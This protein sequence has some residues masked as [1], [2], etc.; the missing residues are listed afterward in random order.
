MNANLNSINKAIRA[1][2]LKVR[3]VRGPGFY[4]WEA[5][6][7]KTSAY[8]DSVYLARAADFP[9]DR[10]VSLARGVRLERDSPVPAGPIRIGTRIN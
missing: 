2:G 1:A 8:G 9:T 6:E 4:F 7:P 10:W 5:T 3:A